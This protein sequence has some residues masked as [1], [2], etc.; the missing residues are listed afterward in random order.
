MEIKKSETYQPSKPLINVLKEQ[1]ISERKKG[2]L[3]DNLDLFVKEVNNSEELSS[4][5]IKRIAG[6]GSFA[7]AFETSDGDILKLSAGSHFP[8]GRP[9]ESFDVPIKK[10]GKI[11]KMHY[12]QEEKLYQHD[13]PEHFVELVI[14]KI[15]KA[16]YRVSDLSTADTHQIGMSEKGELYLLDPECAKFK[17]IFHA[18]FH[19]IKKSASRIHLK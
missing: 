17:T 12:Y 13:M 8:L 11:G 2:F 19:K 15:K 14:E 1:Q 6:N 5:L 16:G 9:Q 18:L 7:W 4:V 10:Q 3:T